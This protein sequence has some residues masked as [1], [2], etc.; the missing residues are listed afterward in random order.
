MIS[1]VRGKQKARFDGITQKVDKTVAVNALM[2]KRNMSKEDAQE[3]VDGA[4][5][6]YNRAVAKAKDAVNDVQHQI[7]DAKEHI[8]ETAE[9]ARI[10]ADHLAS[11]AAKSALAAA[12]ALVL[13]AVV[14]VYAG[15]Y[16]NKYSPNYVVAVERTPVNGPVEVR[17]VQTGY[18]P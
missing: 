16:G 14:C 7:E 11:S 13:G 10:K 18:R 17:T 5:Y 6:A 4:L 3:A 15:H 2:K 12:V 8:R 1:G 9:Q